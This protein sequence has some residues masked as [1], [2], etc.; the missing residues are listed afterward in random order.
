MFVIFFGGILAILIPLWV[1]S[2][3]VSSE[4][5]WTNFESFSGWTNLGL[6]CAIGQT[7]SG[8]AMIGTDGGS[9][10]LGHDATTIPTHAN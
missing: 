2:P 9:P 8:G 4:V 1:L 5:V 10:P 6:A 7:S 3:T